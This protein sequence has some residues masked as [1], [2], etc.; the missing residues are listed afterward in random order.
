M[1]ERLVSMNDGNYRV[2]RQ[3]LIQERSPPPSIS[4]VGD[5][6]RHAD[7]LCYTTLAF[8]GESQCGMVSSFENILL[9]S[10]CTF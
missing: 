2:K 8:L 6:D 7:F 5:T 4:E 1:T 10:V 9:D 3:K